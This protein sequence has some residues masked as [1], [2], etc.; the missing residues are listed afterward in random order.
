MRKTKEESEKTRED[1]LKASIQVFSDK[2]VARSTLAEIAKAAGVTRGAVY[3]HFE[4]KAEIFDALH[5]RMHR[6]F[7]DTILE[8]LE[9]DRPDPVEQLRDLWVKLFCDL[10]EDE[11]RQQGLIL[12]MVKA[13]YSDDLAIYKDK[14]FKKHEESMQLFRHYFQKMKMDGKLPPDIDHDL[15]IEGM[16]CFM[17]G[18]LLEYLNKPES[19]NLENKIPQLIRWFF[20]HMMRREVG[21]K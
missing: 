3:W 4:N 5:E 13:D 9:S 11:Q 20:E 18:V 15:I 7:M 17:K 21:R 2:G 6:P 12:F 8:E 10:S 14:H 1:L 16:F 19:F